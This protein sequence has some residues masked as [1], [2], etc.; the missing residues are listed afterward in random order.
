MRELFEDVD[1][2]ELKVTVKHD[3][4]MTLLTPIGYIGRAHAKFHSKPK[5][6]EILMEAQR[7]N[8]GQV[9]ELN[10]RMEGAVHGQEYTP[11][12]TVFADS[13]KKDLA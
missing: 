9:V 11:A 6:M 12:L 5:Y 10:L 3:H 7:K 13:N 4:S 2:G 1:L 8:K